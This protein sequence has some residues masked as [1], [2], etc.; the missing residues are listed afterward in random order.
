MYYKIY[1]I[2]LKLD[3][4]PYPP[5]THRRML[6][7]AITIYYYAKELFFNDSS[8]PNPSGEEQLACCLSRS[9]N[10]GMYKAVNMPRVC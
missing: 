1:D 9:I 4:P 6:E 10:N 8:P 2:F 5:W 3:N 7:K